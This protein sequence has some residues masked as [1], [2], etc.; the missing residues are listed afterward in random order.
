M[1]RKGK[2]NING[3]LSNRISHSL[4]KQARSEHSR[5]VRIGKL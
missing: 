1:E 5:I 2:Y 3:F 4:L